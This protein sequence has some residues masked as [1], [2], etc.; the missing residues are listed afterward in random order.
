[1][2]VAKY[3]QYAN[4]SFFVLIMDIDHFKQVNDTYGHEVGDQVLIQ[5]AELLRENI[6]F[7][8]M[9]FRYGGEE[10]VVLVP[11]TEV[12]ETTLDLVI[13]ERLRTAIERHTFECHDAPPL[14]KTISIGV[15]RFPDHGKTSH[16]IIQAADEALY[17]AKHNGRNQVCSGAEPAET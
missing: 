13:A 5:L 7:E 12:G 11:R 9:P 3:D 17:R 16:E 1:M 10:F 2:L 15:A 6:R 4:E 8:D 14:K